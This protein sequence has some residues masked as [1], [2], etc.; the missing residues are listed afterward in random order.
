[1]EYKVQRTL[2]R[3]DRCRRFSSLA[4]AFVILVERLER[5][6]SKEAGEVSSV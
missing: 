5:V 2:K 3:L 6:F 1:M 4:V